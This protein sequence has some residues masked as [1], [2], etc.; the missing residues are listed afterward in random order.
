VA[1]AG[2]LGQHL[3]AAGTPGEPRALPMIRGER[4]YLRA[5]ER[6]DIPFFVRWFND[7]E[8]SSFLS[9]RAPLSLPLEENWFERMVEGQGREGYHFVICLLEDER[10]IGTIGLFA[11]DH[12]N[13]GAGMGITI[14]EKALWGKGLGTD[15]L[16]AL[17]DFTFGELRMERVWLDVYEFNARARRS[18]E[19]CGFVLEGTKR[20]GFYRRGSYVDVQLMSILRDEWAGLQRK[21]SWDYA[22]EGS[23][24][25]R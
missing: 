9:M 5:S 10:P 6:S 2:L 24:A 8:T 18:Y 11:I 17:L 13:G 12:L 25:S 15:A 4:V 16:N 20:R 23:A 3:M 22:A 21:R 19:K 14:G 1:A 7:S